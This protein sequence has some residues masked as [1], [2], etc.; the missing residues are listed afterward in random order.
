MN[1]ILFK[2]QYFTCRFAF[3]TVLIQNLPLIS[4]ELIT[5]K[6]VSLTL[7]ANLTEKYPLR[8][9]NRECAQ[10]FLQLYISITLSFFQMVRIYFFVE[11]KI[12]QS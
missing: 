3:N 12:S 6:T 7:I 8:Q 10:L 11:K 2:T 1:H 5:F 4:N 9:I